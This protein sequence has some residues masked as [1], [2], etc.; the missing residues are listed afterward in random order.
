[1]F[2]VRNW[3]NACAPWWCLWDVRCTTRGPNRIL[4]D[5]IWWPI[6]NGNDTCNTS[7]AWNSFSISKRPTSYLFNVVFANGLRCTIDCVL[8]H[9]LGHV[10][11]LDDCLSLFRH[12]WLL[13]YVTDGW[14]TRY[15]DSVV[16]VWAKT[17]SFFLRMTPWKELESTV[18]RKQHEASY[19]A[20]KRKT[21]RQMFYKVIVT[22][23]MSQGVTENPLESFWWLWSFVKFEK[24]IG[25]Q[26]RRASR[27][28]D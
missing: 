26:W 10:R 4:Y 2:R 27:V 6:P 12:D 14:T 8:L 15:R 1:M 19:H 23:S 24:K 17:V 5:R 25:A 3:V 7:N 18:E 9:L 13:L 11:I 21:T 28:E 20:E 16:K 22:L